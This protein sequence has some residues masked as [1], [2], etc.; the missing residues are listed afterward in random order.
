MFGEQKVIFTQIF[1]IFISE[2]EK[3][4][5]SVGVHLKIKPVKSQSLVECY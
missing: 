5:T 2:Y 4:F 1:K 3:R